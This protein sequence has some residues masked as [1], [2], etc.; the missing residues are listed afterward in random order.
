M[1]TLQ[2][3]AILALMTLAVAPTSRAG[4]EVSAEQRK[5]AMEGA[6]LW[7]IYCAQCHNAR[8]GSE[9]SPNQWNAITM[10][11]RT[12]SNMPAKNIRAITEFLK[13]VR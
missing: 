7:P 1:R 2:I 3:T 6:Q 10:H 9:F 4:Q 8:P 11:M 13:T 12:Q 5:L